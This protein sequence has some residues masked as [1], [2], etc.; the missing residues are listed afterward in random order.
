MGRK[1][2]ADLSKTSSLG[3]F[4]NSTSKELK[5]SIENIEKILEDL[6]NGWQ[7]ID[8]EEFKKNLQNYLINLK[9]IQKQTVM[10]GNTVLNYTINYNNM[11]SQ[12][13]EMTKEV[14]KYGQ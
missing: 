5:I 12:Y 8:Y 9:K 4:L 6:E 1:T 7:G 3:N 11:L 13:F 14:N 2:K 10:L